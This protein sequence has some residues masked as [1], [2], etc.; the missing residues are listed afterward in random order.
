MRYAPTLTR[1]FL[2]TVAAL[3]VGCLDSPTD[4]SG[5]AGG[6]RET[7][8]TRTRAD[9]AAISFAALAPGD[10]IGVHFES[11]GCFHHFTADFVLTRIDGGLAIEMVNGQANA[12]RGWRMVAAFTT[13]NSAQVQGLD[14]VLGFYR[15]NRTEGC[16]TVDHVTLRTIGGASQQREETYT[17][18]SCATLEDSTS[19]P[20]VALLR[21]AHD[22]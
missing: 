3:A 10:Q 16:T 8:A 4:P 2:L 20:I 22:S 18:A 1:P 19:F 6:Q 15:R 17:D 13:L 5:T 12:A 9:A 11:R 7:Y 21:L 14:R